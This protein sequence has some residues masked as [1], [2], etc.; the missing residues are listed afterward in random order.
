MEAN[1]GCA[2]GSDHSDGNCGPED[3]FVPASLNSSGNVARLLRQ[4]MFHADNSTNAIHWKAGVP[5]MSPKQVFL[6]LC[7]ERCC[8][9]YRLLGGAL[10]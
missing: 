3:M 4:A 9:R 10:V 2:L 7:G 1:V 8:D 5:V 6:V